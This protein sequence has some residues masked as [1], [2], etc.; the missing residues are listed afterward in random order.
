MTEI[1]EETL[2]TPEI[3]NCDPS[4]CSVCGPKAQLIEP[5]LKF[6]EDLE[7]LGGNDYRQCFQC[8]TCAATCPI[9]PDSQPFPRKEMAWA[10]WG[11]K[12]KLVKDPDIWLCHQ[13][14][15]CSTMCPRGSNPGDL[16]ATIRNFAFQHYSFPGFLG[17]M[18]ADAKFLPVLLGIPTVL[19]I[20]LQVITKHFG[21]PPG[22]IKFERFFPHW[23]LDPLFILASIWAGFALVMGI[24]RFWKDI[25]LNGAK[26]T[27]P[28]GKSILDT[29]NEIITHNKFKECDSSSPRNLSHLLVFYGFLALFIT[30]TAVFFGLYT[31]KV[32]GLIGME[33]PELTPLPMVWYHPVKLL[34]NLGAV[35]FF[36]GLSLM[37]YQ[38]ATNPEK[39]GRSNYYDSLFLAVM[40][41]IGVT[42]IL[43]QLTRLADMAVL[44]YPIYFIHLV[45]VFFLIAYLPYS[46]FAH[47]FYR[48][49]AIVHSKY[50]G[51]K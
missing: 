37:V 44:A 13:C 17:K 10:V 50:T 19:I 27:E 35:L 15:D 21:I 38:R 18:L 24:S 1:V 49:A 48:T 45:F 7:K 26:P 32:L 2:E 30:T 12:D 41:I 31:P 4:T 46:K 14:N 16:I 39:S 47:I 23:L 42:G 40:L 5:D 33:F 36:V 20:V 8:A 28:I 9:S 51:R 6:I 3:C 43:A 34:G 22:E 29:I 25:N 11:L